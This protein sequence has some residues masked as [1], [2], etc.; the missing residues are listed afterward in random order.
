MNLPCSKVGPRL[1]FWLH[2]LS[3]DA[4][5]C[6]CHAL[7]SVIFRNVKLLKFQDVICNL[8]LTLVLIVS[9][10]P[11]LGLIMYILSKLEFPTHKFKFHLL[12]TSVNATYY[13]KYLFYTIQS[14]LI[15]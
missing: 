13:Y 12:T 3:V 9:T 10:G 2:F 4:Y 8:F 5:Q 15:F 7:P 11:C 6:Q 1:H 14:T